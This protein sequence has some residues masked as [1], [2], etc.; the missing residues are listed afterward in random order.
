MTASST[1][2][3]LPV[4]LEPV[5][6]TPSADEEVAL[7][8]GEIEVEL[9][10]QTVVGQ[11]TIC[12]RWRP[13]PAIEFRV[14]EPH[15]P[16]FDHV[17]FKHIR[18]RIPNTDQYL[19][20]F[21]TYSLRGI[22]DGPERDRVLVTSVTGVLKESASFGAQHGIRYVIAHVVNF[23]F[24]HHSGDVTAFDDGAWRRF[25]YG[26]V[27]FEIEGWRVRIDAVTYSDDLRRDLESGGRC[28]IT[29]VL[30]IER[31]DTI[32]FA[33]SDIDPFI[34]AFRRFLL[35]A[36]GSHCDIVLPV[37]FNMAGEPIW[38]GWNLPIQ[39]HWQQAFSW[40]PVE[41]PQVLGK[42]FEGFLRRWQEPGLSEPLDAVIEWYVLCNTFQTGVDGAVM[43]L[44]SSLEIISR[45][46]CVEERQIIT[47][48]GFARLPAADRIRLLL[49]QFIRDMPLKVPQSYRVLSTEAARLNWH[50]VPGVIVELRN[51]VAHPQTRV[52]Q[53]VADVKV[54]AR[55]DAVHLSLWL[56]EL[57]ML[58]FF[59]YKGSYT[60]RLYFEWG[61]RMPVPWT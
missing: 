40:F 56:L 41:E 37:G 32:E 54:E 24:Y 3:A 26:K 44:Q 51:R 1:T 60:R 36:R 10:G 22:Q 12:L 27:D 6:M 30:K 43:L 19:K 39:G 5:Y 38:H 29:H 28:A 23:H 53:R 11:G 25:H 33:P 8:T 58:Y 47:G 20:A 14:P 46:L 31:M 49:A 45:L 52:G 21:A 35:F 34:S 17:E 42:A 9:D 59:S 16:S 50:D 15:G 13:S 7:A 61:R 48:D 2:D 18:V 55:H 57:S 4:P